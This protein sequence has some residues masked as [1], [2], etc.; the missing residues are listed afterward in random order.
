[1]AIFGEDRS[2]GR[3][4]VLAGA[5]AVGAS[6]IAGRGAR[7]ASCSQVV[8]GT[9]GGDYQRL[10]TANVEKPILDPRKIETLH[11]VG[12][13]TA[14]KTKL[15]A[16]RSSR[17]GAMD[18]ICLS[19][20]DTFEMNEAG[21]LAA[22]DV[23][24]VP[25]H[26]NVLKPLIRP[27]AIAHIYSAKVIVYNPGRIKAAPQSYNDLWDPKYK[28]RV[29]LMDGHY[30]QNI[31]SAALIAGGSM[32]DYEPGKAK[33]LELKK[34]VEPKV[35]PS[36]EALA[37]ALKSEEIWITLMFKARG[38]MW[39]KAG[40][41]VES[42]TPR[43]GATP[44]ISDMAIA[45]NAISPDCAWSYME[46]MLQPSAQVG[47]ADRMGYLPTVTNARLPADLEKE[48]GFTDAEIAGFRLP[49]YGYL[50]KNSAQLL[51]WWNKSFKA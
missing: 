13:S 7:A 21:I 31:E 20:V 19:D 5:G 16:A 11:D 30:V 44:Y 27:F 10:L 37:V 1:M 4:A 15:L 34:L 35:Y 32:S 29:G 26:A 40:I 46:A 9:W 38:F 45:K 41:P 50:A 22:I 3:R 51:E 39:K 42:A 8:V 49:D 24:K 18:V 23:A 6:L 2:I 17:R 36:N 25:S 47:F 12:S 48:I 43:E 14:R 33:L 28:G